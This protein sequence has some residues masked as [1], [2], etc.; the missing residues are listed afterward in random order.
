MHEFWDYYEDLFRPV[1]EEQLRALTREPELDNDPGEAAEGTGLHASDE[2]TCGRFCVHVRCAAAIW[3]RE[4]V[5]SLI[6]IYANV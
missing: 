4:D 1:S 5:G 2:S 3:Q 6:S